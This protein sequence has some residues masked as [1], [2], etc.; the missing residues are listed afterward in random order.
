MV[1]LTLTFTSSRL[2]LNFQSQEC[3]QNLLKFLEPLRAVKMQ[4]V[5]QYLP[6]LGSEVKPVIII[7]ICVLASP[8]NLQFQCLIARSA[9]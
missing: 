4:V 9:S 6:K 7:V 2:L 1:N 8:L 3:Q 5:L